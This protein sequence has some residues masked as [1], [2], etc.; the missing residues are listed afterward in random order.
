[1]TGTWWSGALEVAASR[2]L[3]VGRI[4]DS[5]LK[6]GL[7]VGYRFSN[8]SPDLLVPRS[9][10]EARPNTLSARYG[11]GALP[12]HSDGAATEHP[13]PFIALYCAEGSKVPTEV[14]DVFSNK[15]VRKFLSQAIVYSRFNRHAGYFK[16]FSDGSQNRG[17]VRWNP[18]SLEVASP[19]LNAECSEEWQSTQ[20]IIWQPSTI[21]V[22]DNWRMLHRR[23]PVNGEVRRAL[24][25]FQIDKI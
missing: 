13:P 21:A 22:L 25:R 16:A 2:G 23:P 9:Q 11:R 14:L 15:P 4:K 6:D 7:P 18:D 3:Y 20:S 24:V 5:D 19:G 1:M 10:S 8:A 12:W 17:M